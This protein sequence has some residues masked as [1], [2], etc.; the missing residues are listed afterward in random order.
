MVNNIF[1]KLKL[2]LSAIL[3]ILALIAYFSPW[4]S[5]ASR[6]NLGFYI[7]AIF[8]FAIAWIILLFNIFKIIKLR[9]SNFENKKFYIINALVILISYVLL[10][11]GWMNNFMVTV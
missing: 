9:K 8:W 4:W 11:I 1:V 7:L 10:I 2:Y 5:G 3:S 6:T